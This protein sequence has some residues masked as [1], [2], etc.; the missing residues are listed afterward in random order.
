MRKTMVKFMARLMF[1]GCAL[2]LLCASSYSKVTAEEKAAIAEKIEKALEHKDFKNALVGIYAVSLESGKEIYAYNADITMI[3]ASNNKL[4]TTAAA[5]DAL[6][7][8]YTYETDL[9]RV[10]TIKNGIL[11]GHLVIVGSG[12]PTISGRFNEGDVTAALRGWV[13]K[14]KAAGIQRVEGY[15]IG[16]DDLWNDDYYGESWDWS[17]VGEW[18]SAPSS[19]LSF[20]DNCVDL[21]WTPAEKPGQAATFTLQ[22]ET[23]YL[24]FE[25]YVTTRKKG[26]GSDRYY[27][28]AMNSP[29]VRI[30]G[31]ID[32][33]S[34]PKTDSATVDNPTLYFA[35]VLCELLERAGVEVAKGPADI[36]QF[37][38]KQ[39]FQEGR[40][41]IATHQSPPLS[42]IVR[43]INKRSQNF[44][45]DQVLRTLGKAKGGD[46]G[47]R[48]G[49]RAVIE[50]LK[51]K[52]VSTDGFRMSDGSGL[53]WINHTSSRTLVEL[54]RAMR[55]HRHAAAFVDSLPIGGE[56]G[57]LK[58][59][60]GETSRQRKVQPQVRGKTGLIAYTRTLAGYYTSE[61]GEEMV[62]AVML[63]NYTAGRPLTW[64]DRLATIIF[65]EGKGW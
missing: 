11:E 62:F 12:D 56:A 38:N 25:N 7:P 61:S 3:P 41:S 14:V 19:A 37:E 58:Y 42:E 53:S 39:A 10:G 43:V 28:R 60:F 29:D 4:F 15:V 18:Y 32:I 55:R 6:G 63:N 54:L 1:V 47:Y 52:K 17:E 45:A 49:T 46:G 31:G 22:P 50:F 8:D 40:Q 48:S 30:R 9:M 16:D 33:D 27:H 2:L 20:N 35:A 44:Y 13:D 23:Q 26:S 64:I 24:R 34:E 57:T 51:D 5:L 59:R 21:I 36:D 65:T